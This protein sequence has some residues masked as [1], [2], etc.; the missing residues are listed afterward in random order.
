MHTEQQRKPTLVA[1]PRGLWSTQQHFMTSYHWPVE[2]GQGL[3]TSLF[4][5]QAQTLCQ[6]DCVCVC[7]FWISPKSQARL[8]G[9]LL[10]HLFVGMLKKRCLRPVDWLLSKWGRYILHLLWVTVSQL[11]SQSA[12]PPPMHDGSNDGGEDWVK[13]TI[14]AQ[15]GT[16]A[17]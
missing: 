1:H 7:V 12:E 2:D 9:P 5:Q 16:T 17:S 11:V 10:L 3:A 13:N 6:K 4:E 8:R 15:Q 14:L